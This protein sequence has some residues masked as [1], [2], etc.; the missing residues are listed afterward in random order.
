MTGRLIMNTLLLSHF[1]YFLL[2]WMFHD[3]KIDNK[4]SKIQQGALRSA[5]SDNTFQFKELLEE[6]NLAS[7]LA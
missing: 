4:I 1:S 2:I 5:Y 7:S 6:D 3:R